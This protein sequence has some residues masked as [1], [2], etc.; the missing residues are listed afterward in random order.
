[1]VEMN[2]LSLVMIVKD[3]SSS[4]R[5][6][7]ESVKP[8]VDQWTILDTG[9]TDDTIKIIAEVMKDIPGRLFEEPF[10]DYATNRNRVLELDAFYDPSRA[11][12]FQLMLSG[13][14]YLQNGEEL[15]K[16]L[17]NQRSTETNLFRIRLLIEDNRFTSPRVFRT[18]SLWQYEGKVHEFP[19]NPDPAALQETIPNVTIKHIV[20]DPER[21]YSTIWEKHIPLLREQLEEN[22]NDTRALVFLAKSYEALLPMMGEGERVTYAMEAM[23]LYLRRLALPVETEAEKNYL[24]M[25]YLTN[26]RMTGVYTNEEIFSRCKEL[27][28]D[29]PNRPETA[30]LLMYAGA[31]IKLPVLQVY[32][33]AVHAA[34]VAEKA[35]NLESD[36]P[37]STE[38]EWKANHSAAAMARRLA[39]TFSEGSFDRANWENLAQE[40]VEKGIKAGGKPEIFDLLEKAAA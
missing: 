22:P 34:N 25:S 18:G 39:K 20:A 3:E 21:R 24:R 30:L 23:S 12:V 11:A 28:E 13:D 38:V 2:L 10:E 5:E 35:K 7:L 33:L 16:Y 29:D 19:T 17:E 1:M 15:R 14:E 37:I 4:I 32:Q 31:A 9:S 40:H 26:A 6:V 27:A 8:Y 36:S